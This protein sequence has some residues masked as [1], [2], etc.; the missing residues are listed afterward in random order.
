MRPVFY[1]MVDQG[2]VA[3]PSFSFLF[4]KT[5]GQE[6]SKLV[7]G[8][9]HQAYAT[10]DFKYYPLVAQNYWK[11]A[12]DRVSIGDNSVT[13]LSGVVDTGTSVIVGPKSL[14]DPLIQGLPANPDCA[15]LDQYPNM[16]FTIVILYFIQ[17]RGSIRPHS[18]RLLFENHR[19]RTISVPIGSYGFGRS[20]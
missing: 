2:L 12:V 17:G 6:G 19:F 5:A 14:V 20:Y 16:T 15:T 1:D 11:I 3:D 10:G 18:S 8:G 4:S 7:L 13:A 9:V